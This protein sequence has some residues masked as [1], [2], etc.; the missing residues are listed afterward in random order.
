[1]LVFQHAENTSIAFGAVI[2]SVNNDPFVCRWVGSRGR[3][4]GLGTQTGSSHCLGDTDQ[5]LHGPPQVWSKLIITL[6]KYLGRTTLKK[7]NLSQS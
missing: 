5:A 4:G 3:R 2:N 6:Y 7:R 1:M